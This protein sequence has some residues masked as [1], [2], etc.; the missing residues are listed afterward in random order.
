MDMEEAQDEIDEMSPADR[1]Y[2]LDGNYPNCPDCYYAY[3]DG[4]IEAI[5]LRE[6]VI[7]SCSEI[8]DDLI[9][10][11]TY[12]VPEGL[13]AVIDLFYEDDEETVSKSVKRNTRGKTVA[14]RKPATRTQSAKR[15]G[16]ARKPTKAKTSANRKPA[17]KKPAQR[18][19]AKAAPRRR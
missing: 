7:D 5:D 18:K 16:T 17:T 6:Y 9:Y 19:S 14:G 11:D 4:Y 12:D 1:E 2:Y 13:Q 3:F 8:F 15:T 10:K